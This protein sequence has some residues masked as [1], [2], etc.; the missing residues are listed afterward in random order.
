MGI[1]LSRFSHLTEMLV[2]DLSVLLVACRPPRMHCKRLQRKVSRSHNPSLPIV[3]RPERRLYAYMRMAMSG[4]VLRFCS[5]VSRCQS[6]RAGSLAPFRNR[7]RSAVPNSC[8]SWSED[9]SCPLLLSLWHASEASGFH[10][11]AFSPPMCNATGKMRGKL[12]VMIRGVFR[13][14]NGEQTNARSR[15]FEGRQRMPSTSSW[16]NP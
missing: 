11:D 9:R 8:R 4:Y 7:D 1:A 16:R 6:V 12:V 15:R 2:R 3:L 13:L 5:G 10:G 14:L